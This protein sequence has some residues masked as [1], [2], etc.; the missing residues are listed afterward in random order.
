MCSFKHRNKRLLY[1]PFIH[2]NSRCFIT[3]IANIVP[4]QL[5]RLRPIFRVYHFKYL[6]TPRRFLLL[7]LLFLFNLLKA[8]VNSSCLVWAT[9]LLIEFLAACRFVLNR[10]IELFY[11][12]LDSLDWPETNAVASP[13]TILALQSLIDVW[14]CT[15]H[16]SFRHSFEIQSP[17]LLLT[18]SKNHL[19]SWF[20][21]YLIEFWLV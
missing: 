8:L 16:N 5:Q 12:V 6:R 4:N 10:L 2:L 7:L 1:R 17:P 11:F 20:G 13:A 21:V 14:L 3:L 15:V 19:S 9:E 18:L